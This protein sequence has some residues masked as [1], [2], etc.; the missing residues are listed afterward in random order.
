MKRIL[1]IAGTDSSGGAGLTRDTAVAGELGC[2]IKPVVTCVTA[3]TNSALLHIHQVPPQVVAA[4]IEAAC[5]DSPPDAI[6][7]G[8][9]G[10]ADS[11][12]TVAVALAD[13]DIPIVV[14][15]VLKSSSGGALFLGESLQHIFSMAT[16]LTPNLDEAAVLARSSVAVSEHDIAMQ[17]EGLRH[18]GAQAVLIKGGHGEGDD[19]VDLLFQA[20]QR[21][22]FSAARLSKGRRGT[23]CSLATA[24]A[25]HL[26]Q[27]QDVQH[28][29][30]RSKAYIHNWIAEAN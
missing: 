15:P 30:A 19:C 16:L 26:A 29:V 3:Q 12:D 28:A 2:A 1:V 24:I 27:G 7:I 17:A 11:A 9:L 23:G 21:H 18:Q 13:K 14:D 10:S 25:C 20:S 4:Q 5:A 8:M 22:H 6:K